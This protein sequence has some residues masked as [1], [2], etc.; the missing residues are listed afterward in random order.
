MRIFITILL[1]LTVIPTSVVYAGDQANWITEFDTR[2]KEEMR[3]N[4]I[5]GMAVALVHGNNTVL[6]KGY[7]LRDIENNLA[8]DENTLFNIASTH[9]SMNAMLIA[10]LVDDN[11]V[12]WDT[13]VSTYYPGFR[14]RSQAS[15]NS[16]TLSHL[17]SMSSGIPAS[18]EDHLPLEA[19]P[20]DVFETARQS[21]LLGAPL[22]QFSY[23]NISAAIAGYIGVIANGADDLDLFDDYAALLQS[24]ILNPIGMSRS[25]IY[26][27]EAREGGNL[28]KAYDVSNT[29]EPIYV[30]SND[31][32]GDALAPSGSLKSSAKEMA[33]FIST[34]LNRGLAPNGARVV[35]SENLVKTW[36][37]ITGDYALGWWKTSYKNTYVIMHTG[38]YDGFV[39]VLALVPSDNVGLVLMANS[40]AAAGDLTEYAHEILVDVLK[41]S[42]L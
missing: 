23:S 32:D 18:V 40:E 17:L 11:V 10:T 36:Q 19:T 9:K 34:Q 6:A 12:S 27:S 4:K 38:S 16:V 21:I 39:S 1:F 15:T 7:G 35:S 31:L 28:S 37:P 41:E 24:K 30:R 22:E 13:P 33:L 8:V 26:A 20:L 5:P 29:G 42:K 14:L 3:E 2:M 25:T